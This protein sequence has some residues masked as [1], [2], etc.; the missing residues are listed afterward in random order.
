MPYLMSYLYF[1]S[2][3]YVNYKVR[4]HEYLSEKRNAFGS[5]TY[6]YDRPVFDVKQSMVI[7]FRASLTQ[8]FHLDEESQTITVHFWEAY[9]SCTYLPVCLI[10]GD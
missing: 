8:I 6:F 5:E 3:E 4:L 10:P 9:V 1:S 2:V 7:Y